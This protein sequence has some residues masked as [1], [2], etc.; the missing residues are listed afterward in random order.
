M[1]DLKIDNKGDLKLE[2]QQRYPRFTL[3]FRHADYP[4]FSL[5]F[6]QGQT[7]EEV[8]RP[9]DSFTI[10]FRVDDKRGLLEDAKTIP[11]VT[12]MDELKQRVIMRMRTEYGETHLAPQLGSNLAKLK[13][14]N[15]TDEHVRK[16]IINQIAEELGD[17]VENPQIEISHESYDGPFYSQNLTIRIYQKGSL[18]Y[19]MTI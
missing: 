7:Y 17:I 13:H 3:S 10:K 14:K 1:I 2:T 19:N 15:L 8:K 16:E 5:K 12:D 4:I 9:D 6:M 18:I 11:A